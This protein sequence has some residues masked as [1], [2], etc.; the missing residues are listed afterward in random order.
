MFFNLQTIGPELATGKE[1]Q[2]DILRET[3]LDRLVQSI[4]PAE[5][6]LLNHARTG[7]GRFLI[8]AGTK[9]QGS[10]LYQNNC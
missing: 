10:A 6:G 1:H 9:L 5:F 3:E 7:I 4:K 8:I 2:S